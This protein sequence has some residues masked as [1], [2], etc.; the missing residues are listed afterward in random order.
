MFLKVI[1]LKKNIIFINSQTKSTLKTNITAEIARN[2]VKE[3]LHQCFLLLLCTINS[4][5]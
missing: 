1:F 2:S 4:P 3:N 5:G